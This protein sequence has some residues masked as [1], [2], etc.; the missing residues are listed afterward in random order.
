MNSRM[1]RKQPI[2][3]EGRKEANKFRRQRTE[4]DY[5]S[6]ANLSVNIEILVSHKIPTSTYGIELWGCARKPNIPVVQ[7]SQSKI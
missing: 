7:R 5:R 4:L 2:I 1:T 6:G 3:K